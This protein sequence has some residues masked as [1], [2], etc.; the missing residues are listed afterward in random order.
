[1]AIP[2]LSDFILIPRNDPEQ[3]GLVIDIKCAECERTI[4]IAKPGERC[5]AELIGRA[6]LNH[7]ACT[8]A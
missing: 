1:M 5:N 8:D 3:G 7:G 6:Q 2:S 4:W